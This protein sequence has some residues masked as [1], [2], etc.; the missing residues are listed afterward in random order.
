MRTVSPGR[1]ANLLAGDLREATVF[2]KN[3]APVKPE[4]PPDR[5]GKGMWEL[6]A[7]AF[8]D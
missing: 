8:D 6:F 7:G 4:P 1:T 2:E 5:E 3:E